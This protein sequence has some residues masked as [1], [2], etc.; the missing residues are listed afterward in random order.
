MR[1]LPFKF[2]R[3]SIHEEN[4]TSNEKPQPV[5]T[6]NVDLERG[7]TSNSSDSVSDDEAIQA[8]E[9]ENKRSRWTGGVSTKHRKLVRIFGQIGF[10]AKGM[11]YG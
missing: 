10:C 3:R 7:N 8:Q 5:T 11:V 6:E 9:N 4:E 1:F 2:S